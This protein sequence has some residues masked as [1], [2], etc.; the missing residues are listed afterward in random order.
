[1]NGIRKVKICNSAFNYLPFEDISSFFVSRN[2][3]YKIEKGQNRNNIHEMR[4]DN[5]LLN[6]NMFSVIYI[7]IYYIFGE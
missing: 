1:M 2:I 6:K 7:W 4:R 5:H 3:P